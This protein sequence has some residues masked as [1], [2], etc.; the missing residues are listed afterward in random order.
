MAVKRPVSGGDARSGSRSAARQTVVQRTVINVNA[1]ARTTQPRTRL[2]QARREAQQFRKRANAARRA[3][4]GARRDLGDAKK[5]LRRTTK[6]RDLIAGELDWASR[7]YGKTYDKLSAQKKRHAAARAQL[8][9][10]LVRA[11]ATS[12]RL[13]QEKGAITREKSALAERLRDLEGRNQGETGAAQRMRTQIQ[14]LERQVGE[15][16]RALATARER[17]ESLERDLQTARE[18]YMDE[19]G[20]ADA[21]EGANQS[22]H[23]RVRGLRGERDR[24]RGALEEA[25]RGGGDTTVIT[26]QLTAINTRITNLETVI[27]QGGVLGHDGLYRLPNGMIYNPV[28]NT[29]G[30]GGVGAGHIFSDAQFERLITLL[31]ERQGVPPAQVRNQLLE[32]IQAMQAGGMNASEIRK[33][34]YK[35]EGVEE[36]ARGTAKFAKDTENIGKGF[37]SIAN[38]FNPSIFGNILVIVILVLMIWIVLKM[39]RWF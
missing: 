17:H 28:Q 36:S 15:R 6:T 18:D 31:Q 10:E 38:I 21:A 12:R 37:G 39:F 5:T 13:A 27:N 24:L 25:R 22:L 33:V 23:D 9:E 2:D 29:F 3:E 4:H 34:I 20:R 16:D 26:Q 8:R 35:R 7:E 14:D 11:T 19:R 30:G 32:D 1:P